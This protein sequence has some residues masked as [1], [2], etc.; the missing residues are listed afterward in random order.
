[1]IEEVAHLRR[2]EVR[3][4]EVACGFVVLPQPKRCKR[5]NL[6]RLDEGPR[7][8]DVGLNQLDLTMSEL[9]AARLARLRRASVCE[10]G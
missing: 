10:R 8:S 3:R 1:M 5:G 2:P 6:V 4:N 9:A 7:I